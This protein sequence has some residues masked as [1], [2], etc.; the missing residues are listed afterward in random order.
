LAFLGCQPPVPQVRSPGLTGTPRVAAPKLSAQA[1]QTQSAGRGWLVACAAVAA[2]ILRKRGR[3]PERPKRPMAAF[4]LFLNDSRSK[5]KDLT[6]TEIAKEAGKEWST[7]SKAKKKPYEAK[8]LKAKVAYDKAFKKYVD[9]GRAEEWKRD[10]NKPKKPMTSFFLFLAENKH[11]SA[12]QAASDWNALPA[13][14]KKLY[15]TKYEKNQAKYDKDMEKY[16]A[17]GSEEKWKERVGIKAF[18]DEEGKRKQLKEEKAKAEKEKLKAKAEKEKLKEKKLRE[19]EREK[20]LKDR[21]RVKAKAE[22]EK[23]KEKKLRETEKKKA[24]KDRQRAKAKAEKEKFRVK[25]L[26]EK[27]KT[28]LK[29]QKERLKAKALKTVRKT[30]V[31]KALKTVTA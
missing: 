13:D 31:K 1:A 14:K 22:K 28:K 23:L 20:A 21:Q 3:D 26:K 2:S 10:P 11:T 27:E 9:S 15:V 4:F 24:L 19:K 18:E 6:V 30:G 16:K 29:L 12:A 5:K 8:A 7:M 25:A 17:S